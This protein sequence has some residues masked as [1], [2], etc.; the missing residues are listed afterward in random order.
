MTD[1]WVIALMCYPMD[2]TWTGS[3]VCAENLNVIYT[4]RF[5]VG[6]SISTMQDDAVKKRVVMAARDNWENY[7]TC[8]FPVEVKSL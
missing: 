1:I 6:P 3:T 7:F 2:L 8:L 5:H 4:G